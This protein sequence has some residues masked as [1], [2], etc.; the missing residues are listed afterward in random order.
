MKN[1][2]T[3]A[4]LSARTARMGLD[5]G[6]H[7]SAISR[8]YYAMFDV[9]RA[10]LISIDH[11]LAEAKTHTT[12]VRRFSKHLVQERGFD[13]ALAKILKDAFETRQE[14]DYETGWVVSEAKTRQ[15]VE[16]RERFIDA[17]S[18]FEPG[19]SP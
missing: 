6:D 9:A 19:K 2:W 7:V 11:R 5:G 12:I 16:N 10:V 14:A 3:Q 8:A 13:R 17:L 18:I 15:V 4:R 1:L